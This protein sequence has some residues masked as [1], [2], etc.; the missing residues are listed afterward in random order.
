[1]GK[2]L[3][4]VDTRSVEGNGC[5]LGVL[6]KSK[7]R[8]KKVSSRESTSRLYRERE[9]WASI[10]GIAHVCCIFSLSLDSFKARL[11]CEIRDCSCSLL[12]VFFFLFFFP[13]TVHILFYFIDMSTR[14]FYSRLED[15][16]W[17]IKYQRLPAL[18]MI[19]NNCLLYFLTE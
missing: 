6:R 7:D 16:A 8:N 18:F 2:L 17:D 15:S 13:L 4:Y 5:W 1:M 12:T 19:A 10:R 9:S 14:G 11:C 3:E